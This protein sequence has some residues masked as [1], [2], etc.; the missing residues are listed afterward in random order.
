M[1]LSPYVMGVDD[2]VVDGGMRDA[3]RPIHRRASCEG[4]SVRTTGSCV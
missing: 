2:V 4:A 3:K 1:S